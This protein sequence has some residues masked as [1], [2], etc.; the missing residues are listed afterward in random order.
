MTSNGIVKMES[1]S[2]EIIC[3]KTDLFLLKY[4]KF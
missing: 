3:I 2:D 1:L 4:F